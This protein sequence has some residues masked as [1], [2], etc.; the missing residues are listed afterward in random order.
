LKKRVTKYYLLLGLTLIFIVFSEVNLFAVSYYIS[1]SGDDSN[2]GLTPTQAWKTLAKV[3]RA[4]LKPGDQV[5]FDRGD[6]WTGTIKVN[7]SGK[8][9]SPIIY[10]A[11][12]TGKNPV[13]SGFTTVSEWSSEGNG[14]YSKVIYPES[15]PNMLI[16]D[17]VQYALG[18]YPNNTNLTFESVTQNLTI[19]DNQLT[20][21]P[22]WTGAE[23]VI[24]KNAWTIENCP[25][26][27]HSANRISFTSQTISAISQSGQYFIQNNIK[28][29]D[30]YGE[31]YYNEST[32]KLSV[33]FGDIDPT[34][35][36]T[37]ISVFNN[38]IKNTGG[39]DYI[40]V[41]DI[42]L[43]GSNNSAVTFSIGTT[44]C[45]FTNCNVSF[46][47]G[48]GFTLYGNN[49]KVENCHISNINGGNPE[50]INGGGI[51]ITGINAQVKGNV[52]TNIGL[53]P[54]QTSKIVLTIGI[55][56]AGNNSVVENN[57]LDSTAYMGI[58]ITA[59]AVKGT[60]RFNRVNRSGQLRS[61]SGGIYLGHDHQGTIIEY[62]I[63]SNTG[64]NGIYLDENCTG[65][66]VSNNTILK[67]NDNG[68]KIH[69]SSGNVIKFNTIYD[70]P[71]GINYSNWTP[72]KTLYNNIVTDNIIVA[73]PDQFVTE[74]INRYAGDN[75]F[76]TAERNFYVYPD[77]ENKV[78]T[79]NTVGDNSTKSFSIWKSFSRLDA[80]SVIVP[81]KYKE[82]EREKLLY[83]NTT[84]NITFNLGKSTFKDVKG[85]KYVSSFIL[86]PFTSKVLIGKNF[87]EINLKPEISD[88]SFHIKSPKYKNDSLGQ[89][90]AFD[91]DTNQ[92]LYYSIYNGNEM[93]W[94][95]V[96]SVSGKLFVQNDI[97]AI[98]KLKVE[99]DVIVKD[100]SINSLSDSAKILIY[101]EGTDTSPPEITSFSIPRQVFSHYVPVE[102]FT[103]TD[104]WGVKGVL[105]SL[106]PEIPPVDDNSW[107]D[108]IPDF[109]YLTQPGQ[110]T[111]YAWAIDFSDNISQPLT[112]TVSVSFPQMA[113]TYS[114]YLFEEE[115]GLDVF[116]SHN[117][118]NGTIKNFVSRDEGA[119]GNGLIFNGKGYVDLG[120]NFGENVLDRFT[121]STW[122]KPDTVN[123]YLPILTHGGFYSNTFELYINA[124]SASIL[125]NTNG[126]LNT[127]L[128][129]ENIDQLWDG[130]WHHLAVKYNGS[131]KTIY[132]DG[133]IIAEI[134]DTGLINSGFWNNLYIGA[135]ISQ[136]DSSFYHGAMDEV[137]IYNFALTQDEID[138]LYHSVNK[139]LN[140]INT[141]EYISICE[142]DNYL[143]WKETGSYTRIIQ[144][145]DIAAS[146]ADSI[147]TTNIIVQP[148]YNTPLEIAICEE[149]TLVF[150]NQKI[151]K[152]G[153]YSMLLNS[154]SGCD[155]IVILKLKVHSKYLVTE[156]ISILTGTNYLGWVTDGT[157]QRNLISVNGCDSILITNLSVV[158]FFTHTVNLEKGWNIFST[159]LFPTDSNF[160]NILEKLENQNILI[161]VQ[162]EDENS[163]R[164]EDDRWINGIGEIKESEGYKIRVNS[165]S[166]LKIN[167]QPVNLPLNIHLNAGWNII[168][169]P[170]QGK[171]NAMEVIQPLINE[172]I[173]N[174]VL[175]ERGNSI[176]FWGNKI[177]WINGIGNFN[178][179]DGYLMEVNKDGVL[180]IL[181]GYKKSGLVL[182]SESETNHFNRIFEGNGFGHMNINITGL[183][184][185]QLEVGDEIAAYDGDK[186]VGTAKLSN[187]N[188][189]NDI[190]S[191]QASISDKEIINGFTEGNK[192]ELLAWRSRNDEEFRPNS[193]VIG[194]TP[195]YKKYGSVFFLLDIANSSESIYNT[196]QELKIFPNPAMDIINIVFQIEPN[197]PT[198]IFL[199]DLT[200]KQILHREAKSKHEQLNIVSQ[201][202][203]I[204]LIKIVSGETSVTKKIFKR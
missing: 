198:L 68:I 160:G 51:Y 73:K 103:V 99:L 10:G 9:D 164:N 149:D 82:G 6:N 86:E 72:N 108:S 96:D 192:I 188:I 24:Y 163:Y 156:E 61:D 19:I 37:K 168:S 17:E 161:E 191:I 100:N 29:L 196:L 65:V 11:Y 70:N 122:I 53:I 12:G 117:L 5:L 165:G 67:S 135:N 171:V 133:K 194:G 18:R 189:T 77:Y 137:R 199:T 33:F 147:I 44:N 81:I 43:E 113:A 42:D 195:I 186:C 200:G 178:T 197:A 201:P 183:T 8:V 172:G 143:G 58:Y 21:T 41:Q 102:S 169:F 91:T 59:S 125:F 112:D 7:N 111:L 16:I 136:Y 39:F 177:G 146:G 92:I 84:Q 204:Y 104:D 2:S 14:I 173:L 50:Q 32:K 40:V 131:R 49:N 38:L 115:N 142:G 158:Q 79:V 119:V 153:T 180:T 98:N 27:N 129:V 25:I 63:I 105:L 93:N 166:E 128:I 48:D 184:D 185:L 107:T 176:E 66:T 116:D 47:G 109:F 132:L 60:I 152:S 175:D 193:E 55:T 114:E 87:E 23:V 134:Q 71:V 144:R 140:R 26:T 90:S 162:D 46:S 4:F 120:K 54:G 159:Y 110:V 69:I 28:T 34:T 64:G 118:V 167:G 150:N 106:T 203:G 88:Q 181:K 123:S 127:A 45:E 76:G 31:W 130:N 154:V 3:N 22:N 187:F 179:G 145:K 101:I 182:N 36:T 202:S 75:S 97:G 74:F 151:Y 148:K 30:Q 57:I 83:N 35:K 62:N 190:V 94:F 170:Y 157:Y 56:I 15:A 89:I 1:N 85:E 126:T 78:F 124:D 20:E 138:D 121:I 95:S 139:V 52:L 13:I 80:S 174:K 155:S 141:S